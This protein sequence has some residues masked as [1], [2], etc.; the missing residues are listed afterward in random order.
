DI[1]A[2]F[3]IEA[4]LENLVS[5]VA[6]G[7]EVPK[8]ARRRNHRNF[9]SATRVP[10]GFRNALRKPRLVSHAFRK[11]GT[12]GH[13]GGGGDSAQKARFSPFESHVLASRW[14]VSSQVVH[15]VGSM[16]RGCGMS[17]RNRL[18][19]ATNLACV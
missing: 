9:K 7:F 8:R 11:P 13:G 1:F 19:V 18:G 3:G 5:R 12:R 2:N 16:V 14:G 17:L 15:K 6:Y 10:F 4:T